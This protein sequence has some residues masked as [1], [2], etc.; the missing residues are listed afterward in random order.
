MANYYI[1]N[2][3]LYNAEELKHWKY[4]SKER[5]NGKWRYK[6]EDIKTPASE[7]YKNPI[8]NLQDVYTI[9]DKKGNQYTKIGGVDEYGTYIARGKEWVMNVTEGNSLFTK[10]SVLTSHGPTGANH[11]KN[12]DVKVGLISQFIS[13]AKKWLSNLF[14]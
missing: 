12:I 3:Q 10:T 6:Y 1:H 5:V 13:K 4:I 11:Y 14:S 2:G 7:F 8:N 9:H